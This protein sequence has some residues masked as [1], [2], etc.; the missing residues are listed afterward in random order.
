[1][2]M[3][4]W[5]SAVPS[6]PLV[7]PSAD[8]GFKR[9]FS[10]QQLLQMGADLLEQM[11]RRVVLAITHAFI[12]G[13]P[14]FEQLQQWADQIGDLLW[15]L[16]GDMLIELVTE[17]IGDLLE[18]NWLD[19]R[20]IWQAVTS[21]WDFWRGVVNWAMTVL[22]NIT[23][24]DLTEQ[25]QFL[26]DLAALFALS[27]LQAVWVAFF[28]GWDDLN[29]SNPLQAIHNAWK[30]LVDLFWGVLDWF[31]TMLS[32]L[33]G[34][35]LPSFLE[36]DAL[37]AAWTGFNT[38][39]GAINWSNPLAA[40]HPAWMA[41]VDLFWDMGTWAGDVLRNLT[42]I[43]LPGFF[44]FSEIRAAWTT[45]FDAWGDINWSNPLT[46]IHAA[47]MLLVD[48]GG[49]IWA[50][51]KTVLGNLTG[52]TLPDFF[53]LSGVKALWDTFTSAWDGIDWGDPLA[54]LHTAWMRIVDL[55]SGAWDWILGVIENLTGISIPSF[56]DTA[57]L[58]SAWQT[59][60]N[61]WGDINWLSLTAIWDALRA[62]GTLIRSATHW[63]L[64]VI[65]N[66]TGIDLETIADSFG[67]G[68]LATALTTWASSLA[69]INWANPVAGLMDAIAA[70]IKLFQD[71][72]NWLLGVI[73]SWL[74]WNISAVGDMFSSVGAFIERIIEYFWGDTG[75]G[76]WLQTIEALV[77]EAGA[78]IAA[79][80]AAVF[81][82]VKRFVG[83]F[84]EFTGLSGLVTFFG[85]LFGPDGLLGWLAMMRDKLTNQKPLDFSPDA[86]RKA[87]EEFFGFGG[88]PVA[89]IND[90]AVNLLSQGNFNNDITIDPAGGW[91]WDGTLTATGTG[92]SARCD[93]TGSLQ[94]LYSRQAIK[95]ANGDKVEITAKVRTS[96]FT[97]AGGRY[98]EL[99]IV[100]W[101]LVSNVMTAQT[102]VVIHTRTSGSP[103]AFVA[104]TGST[105]TV[106]SDV[107]R[108]TV[109]LSVVANSGA[110]VW[111]DDVHVTKTGKMQ[112]SF[113]D[114]LEP[115]WEGVWAAKFGGSGVGKIWSDFITAITAI[116]SDA[117]DA[118][119]DVGDLTTGLSTS[120]HSWIGSI[121]SVVVDGVTNFQGF[122]NTLAIAMGGSGSANRVSH[123]GT[124]AAAVTGTADDAYENA[125]D[126]LVLA[127]GTNTAAYNAWY[128]SGGTGGT[129]NMTAVINSIKSSVADGWTVE[130]INTSGTWTRPAATD[131]IIEFWAICVG[132]G[133]GG[134]KGQ[135]SLSGADG[136]DG[137]V[138]GRW[139][140]KQI[141]PSTIPGTVTCTVG[142]GG[143]GRTSRSGSAPDNGNPSS[144]GSLCSSSEALAASIGSL[145]GFYAATDSRPGVGGKGGDE[146]GGGK[147]GAAGASTPLAAGGGGGAAGGAAGAPGAAATLTGASRAGGGGGG[148]G[149]GTNA[150]PYIG[151]KG[152]AGGRPGGGGGGGGAVWSVTPAAA[153]DGGDGGHG[154]IILLY[155]I[156][157]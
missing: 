38:A 67:I 23:G 31:G 60:T 92:G 3:P 40:I 2:G 20:A 70:F 109:R 69:A 30:L 95:T 88:I 112:Q 73:E 42:G 33:T 37:K 105:Y 134:D 120:P 85:D 45:F 32:N 150:P 137:G 141:T 59:F 5:A 12:P 18:I 46:G 87:L 36:F 80:I 4:E 125:D 22:K 6:T 90:Q 128:G 14:A 75:L 86:I 155:R 107:I 96:S 152:G 53:N 101:K 135:A 10:Q 119:G 26:K 127:A 139:M 71:I 72:G 123:V 63:L 58:K 25:S 113:V 56:F 11:L 147:A 24:I 15:W 116:N 28:N 129:A 41:V 94:R 64:G 39:W 65:K 151:G 7:H 48:L 93:A 21:S 62:V 126:A 52:I 132:S 49:D 144:F 19:P 142:A 82:G 16:E 153:G 108:L 47:W 136:G 29:W 115:T 145:V 122:L 110:T 50:W 61:A 54:A 34:I 130:V 78:S 79:A 76:G 124:R 149:G 27:D 57:T 35:E 131:R 157:T 140:A 154:N 156:K 66:L 106:A 13:I 111:F 138:P 100:P 55:V 44:A 74:G 97:A 51:V 146:A 8:A 148:G 83:L 68:A 103:G 102:P 114:N 99:A 9:P 1:M 98:M 81:N 77:G 104:M 133:G 118:L 91:T 121:L 84:G 43:D 17:H 143:A 117:G 89:H